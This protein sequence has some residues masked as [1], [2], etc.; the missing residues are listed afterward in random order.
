MPDLTGQTVGFIGLGL[1]GKPMARNLGGAGATVVIHNRSR[2]PVDELA[3][4]GMV[5]ANSPADVARK[6]E[7]VVIMVADTAAVEHVLFG[8]GGVAEGVGPGS[9]VI[10]M[11]TTAVDKTRA[12]IPVCARYIPAIAIRA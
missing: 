9:L 5:A 8:P 12:H 4:E 3:G 2:G 1:M 6:A 11:G 7:S 10:D